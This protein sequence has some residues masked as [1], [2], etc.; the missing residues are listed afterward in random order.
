M[1]VQSGVLILAKTRID[2][3]DT[4]VGQK[5]VAQTVTIAVWHLVLND[6]RPPLAIGRGLI[7]EPADPVSARIADHPVERGHKFLPWNLADVPK[8]RTQREA[9]RSQARTV[10]SR[11]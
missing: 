1:L 7:Y 3:G 6:T 5:V 11:S 9:A 4:Q 10:G 8:R 2:P